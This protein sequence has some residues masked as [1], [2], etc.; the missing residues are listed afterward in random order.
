MVLVGLMLASPFLTRWYCLWQVPDVALP[1]DEEA[2]L[3]GEEVAEEDDAFVE[4][5]EAIR[6][7]IANRS[8][9]VAEGRF[10]D[11]FWA[12]IPHA[13]KNP[14]QSRDPKLD[15][16]IRDNSNTLEHYRRGGEK[17]LAKG[18]SLRTIHRSTQLTAHN[19]L[20]RLAYMARIQAL[21][22]EESGD[23]DAAWRWHRTNLQCARHSETPKIEVC[24]LVGI[25][26]RAQ[27]ARGIVRWSKSS[28]V[29][30]Q[31]LRSA[32]KEVLSEAVR[33]TARSDSS[34]GEYFSCR[35]T[36]H[37]ID[38][39]DYVL[40]AWNKGIAAN[41]TWLPL[42]RIG[43]WIF[44]QPE[45]MLRIQRQLLVNNGNAIDLPL[46]QRAA[47]VPCDAAVVLEVRGKRLPGQLEPEAL[48]RLL[49][50]SPWQMDGYQVSVN[51]PYIDEAIQLEDARQFALIVLLACQEYHRDHGEFPDS[52]KD[53]IPAYL[54]AIPSDPMCSTAV[55]M[56]Y[57]RNPGGDA[58]VWSASRNGFYDNEVVTVTDRPTDDAGYL[59]SRPLTNPSSALTPSNTPQEDG[60]P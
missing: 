39:P 38:A 32:R 23:V 7:F 53:L 11:D 49:D 17:P 29:T 58:V 19:D 33:R 20:Q 25:G 45:M 1:F 13:L 34:R 27:A 22:C 35:N 47:A 46:S 24:H 44:G 37:R 42:K 6:S 3:L 55:P 12:S 21:I 51:T 28:F 26:I 2:F 4:Y 30:A 10:T 36:L 59:I 31:Q 52:A 14:D 57:R 41:P 60:R 43:L 15:E 18:P 8:N 54:D 56:R 16:W 48:A 9:G 40:P 5:Q 50:D